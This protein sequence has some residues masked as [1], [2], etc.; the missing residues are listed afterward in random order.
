MSVVSEG[1]LRMSKNSYLLK[2]K[3]SAC[4]TKQ[5]IINDEQSVLMK[6]IVITNK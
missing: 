6:K 3:K 2:V 5:R 4:R 1:F